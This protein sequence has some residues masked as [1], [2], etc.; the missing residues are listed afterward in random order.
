MWRNGEHIE[1]VPVLFSDPVLVLLPTLCGE[2][3]E[4]C[5]LC[6]F[7]P[8]HNTTR[9]RLS[10]R[11]PK[12]CVSTASPRTQEQKHCL[13]QFSQQDS[14]CLPYKTGVE[15]LPLAVDRSGSPAPRRT[16]EWKRCLSQWKRAE[17]L[18]LAVHWSGSTGV[19]SETSRS[20][21]VWKHTA[22]CSTHD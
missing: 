8:D 1:D 10:P 18:P 16:Q 19:K 15:V 14:Y 13:P 21:Q 4:S 9:V 12:M 7:D 3:R 17:I 6:S 22:S 11:V 20:R 2:V 5:L